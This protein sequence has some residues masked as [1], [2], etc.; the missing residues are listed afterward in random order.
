MRTVLICCC[1]ATSGFM[2]GNHVSALRLDSND[3]GAAIA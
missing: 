1:D 3:L 2:S